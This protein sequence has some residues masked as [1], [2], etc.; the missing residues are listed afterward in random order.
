MPVL[1]PSVGGVGVVRAGEILRREATSTL[2]AIELNQGDT[3]EFTLRGR[4]RWTM[5]LLDTWA[6]VLL[7]NLKDTHKGHHGGGTVYAFGCTIEINGQVMPMV[8]YVPVQASF[9]EPYVVNGVRIWFDG[10][11]DI[12]ELFN[13]THGACLPN[14]DARFAIQDAT[15]PICPEEL[16]PWYP[17]ADNCL[18]VYKCYNGDDTWMGPY[19]GSDLHGGLDVNMPI[20]TPLWAPIAFDGQ[21]YFN[22]LAM[23]HNNNRW[24]AIRRWGNGQRWVLQAH[25]ITRLL[26]PE[27]APV[28]RGTH[29]AVAAG[30]LTGSHAH[31]HFV[32][33]VGEEDEEILLDPWILFWQIF[34]NNK[35]RAGVIQAEMEPLA[36][37]KTGEQVDFDAGGSRPGVAGGE[38]SYCWTFG[39]GGCSA[40]A[41]PTHSFTE[42]GIYP[43]TLTVDDGVHRDIVTQHITVTGRPIDR[44]SLVL[45]APDEL[46]FLPRP[47][48]VMDVYGD[49]PGCAPHTLRFTARPSSAPR[50][51]AKRIEV[52]NAGSGVL[53]QAKWSIDH[54][55]VDGWVKVEREGEGNAQ[56]LRVNV[57]AGGMKARHGIY[58]AIVRVACPGAV[59]SPQCFAL[60]LTT[61][62]SPPSAEVV[63]D[64]EDARCHATPYHWHAPRFHSAWSRGHD[65]TYLIPGDDAISD[66][67]VRYQPD[68]A[69]GRYEV[70][71]HE[72]TPIRPT[73]QSPSEVR[74]R[75][76]V[77]HKTGANVVW[78]EPLNSRVI[79]TFDFN[80]GTDGCAQ[81]ES[82]GATGLVVAD[83]IRFRPVR[84]EGHR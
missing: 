10:V 52:C 16:R 69:A 58:H 41:A 21:Y 45:H 37:T 73:I 27:K 56:S 25:H 75:V 50:P 66:G 14:K 35:R 62:P 13:E 12:G 18:D 23:G 7:T 57:D 83:A 11:R 51:P 43:V 4:Q 54:S 2:T 59:N 38:L 63:I 84:D 68:L 32:F 72:D 40:E 55:D 34:E 44:P 67:I 53:A 33:K 29:Y 49:E 5:R 65:G 76:R 9:Y 3:L 81:I 61:P 80:E 39:D 82:A 71:L 78:V 42:A 60:E 46:E 15:I 17:S 24:R 64:N 30:V 19:F 47:V 74:Y 31:S 1:A 48:H 79:G 28:E 22:S 8:R 77:F 26:V 70:L 20:G 6:R 36:P